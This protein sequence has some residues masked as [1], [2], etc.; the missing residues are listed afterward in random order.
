MNPLPRIDT[1]VEPEDKSKG[2]IKK[3]QLLKSCSYFNRG[4]RPIR[5][6]EQPVEVIDRGGACDPAAL[7]PREGD[8]WMRRF[9]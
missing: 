8:V 5:P 6:K 4:S 7:I 3:Q 1:Y 2:Y 9:I